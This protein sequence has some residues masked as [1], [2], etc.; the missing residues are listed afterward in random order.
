MEP[1]G[2]LAHLQQPAACLCAQSN[3]FSPIYLVQ[4]I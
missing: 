1:E 4:S 3:L 2:S